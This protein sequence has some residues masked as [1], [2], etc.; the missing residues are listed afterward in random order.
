MI[1]R[2]YAMEIRGKNK[3]VCVK[4]SKEKVKREK[5]NWEAKNSVGK[6]RKARAGRAIFLLL[7]P[8]YSDQVIIA[9]VHAH[10]TFHGCFF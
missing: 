4:G 3:G 8:R 2:L 1:D 10:P 7:D 6:R 5:R 9:R